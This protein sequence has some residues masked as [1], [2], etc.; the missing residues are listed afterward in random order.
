MIFVQ[1]YYYDE[2]NA[3][4]EL[5]VRASRDQA[6]VLRA[7]MEDCIQTPGLVTRSPV[8]TIDDND[9]LVTRCQVTPAEAK[10]I[11]NYLMG[12]TST[13]RILRSCCGR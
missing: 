9:R 4:N 3:L 13:P 2:H 6:Q 8:I 1:F 5:G 11:L 12:K 7:F 10:A